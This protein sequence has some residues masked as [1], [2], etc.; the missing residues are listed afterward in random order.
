MSEIQSARLNYIGISAINI[1]KMHLHINLQSDCKSKVGSVV[2][3]GV[4]TGG[5]T[6]F[7]LS[8]R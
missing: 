4:Q 1:L 2:H 3:V 6:S 5:D 8:C 7:H